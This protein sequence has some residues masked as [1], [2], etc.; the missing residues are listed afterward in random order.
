MKL[1]NEALE[2]LN[3]FSSI[4]PSI[5]F[6]TG[7]IIRTASPALDIFAQYESGIDFPVDA[8]VYNLKK[9]LGVLSLFDDPDLSFGDSRLEV[10]DGRKSVAYALSEVKGAPDKEPS[11]PEAKARIDLSGDDLFDS[12]KAM[13][14]LEL[15]EF[16]LGVKDGTAWVFGGDSK[17]SSKDG[18]SSTLPTI[19]TYT[20]EG[21]NELTVILP[22]YAIKLLKRDYTVHLHPL[23]AK[24]V[25]PS[26]LTYWLTSMAT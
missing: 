12:L 7:N 16:G 19:P 14:I 18:Y 8:G 26:G 17:N 15:P 9:F 1:H 5:K 21:T 10:S 24:F 3:N 11:V 13:S 2:V 22:R 4:N 23:Y 6:K 25:S 20:G